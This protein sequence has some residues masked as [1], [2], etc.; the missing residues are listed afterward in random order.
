VTA[1]R[2]N[3]LIAAITWLLIGSTVAAAQVSPVG[4][5]DT[6]NG[7]GTGVVSPVSPTGAYHTAVPLDLPA[8]R[9][10]VPVPLSV[11][12][13]GNSQAGAPG[14]G[15]EIPIF[16]I[17]ASQHSW[18]RKPAAGS[19]SAGEDL[20]PRR[21]LLVM[22]GGPQLLVQSTEPGVY[23]P[24]VSSEY[25]DVLLNGDG[26]LVRTASNLEYRFSPA[27][28]FGVDD[29]T[30]W[31]L[32]QVRDRRGSDRVDIEYRVEDV[33][34]GTELD[35]AHLRYGFD[36]TVPLGTPLYDVEL[37][38]RSWTEESPYTCPHE[39][40]V[41]SDRRP[42]ATSESGE[43]TLI[44]SRLLSQIRVIAKDNLG[45]TTNSKII[46][47]YSFEYQPDRATS[48]PRLTS[49]DVQAGSAWMP[50]ARYEYGSVVDDVPW[51]DGVG[52]VRYSQ[53]SFISR[54]PAAEAIVAAG[55]SGTV[56]EREVTGGLDNDVVERAFLRH[57]IRDLTGDGVPDLVYR[58]G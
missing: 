26:W 20:F 52:W 49:V 25:V 46:R 6:T 35:V 9:G 36:N 19:N 27:S 56:V 34:C 5:H 14:L 3:V 24:F 17:R 13:N 10:A 28:V 53:P 58:D 54:D 47:S 51:R 41:P 48:L 43:R 7:P 39:A 8:P 22:G 15:W 55:I 18:H 21:M 29:D 23:H 50:V 40:N 4:T 12:Y 1:I 11:I 38:Y 32:V 57:A 33:G 37:Q 16:H 44:R 45:T 31:L 2:R 42:F 30:L